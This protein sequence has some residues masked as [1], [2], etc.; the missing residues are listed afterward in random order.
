[1]KPREF[2]S[3]LGSGA[4][5]PLASREHSNRRESRGSASSSSQRIAQ[6]TTCASVEPRMRD[7]GPAEDMPARASKV[8]FR[9]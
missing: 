1:M 7:P 8:R 5:W 2:I 4:L 9:A 3:L 6:A